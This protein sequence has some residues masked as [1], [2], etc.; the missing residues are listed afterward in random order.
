MTRYRRTLGPHHSTPR[1][2]STRIYAHISPK[3]RNTRHRRHVHSQKKNEK[4]RDSRDD[5]EDTYRSLLYEENG[6][7]DD[8]N[9]SDD[10]TI[11][12]DNSEWDEETTLVEIL[13]SP[14]L[15]H[16]HPLCFFLLNL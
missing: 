7:R 16:F 3:S 11:S 2:H 6:T 9:R 14:Y 5:L 12:S 10:G 15:N 13:G 4:G 1:P 8:D